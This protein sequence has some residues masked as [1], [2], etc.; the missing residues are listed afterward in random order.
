MQNWPNDEQKL[1]NPNE[2]K[3]TLAV[4]N[5]MLTTMRSKNNGLLGWGGR[6]RTSAWRNQNPLPYRLA[7]P[8]R[9]FFP[10]LPP[11]AAGP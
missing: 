1:E 10:G 8:Q 3:A 2:K 9:R 4:S 11:A 7:T 6:I 5:E